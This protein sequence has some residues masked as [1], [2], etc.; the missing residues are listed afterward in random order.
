MNTD[1]YNFT[2]LAE[3]IYSVAAHSLA[4]LFTKPTEEAM[5]LSVEKAFP[6]NKSLEQAPLFRNWADL[7]LAGIEDLAGID[8]RRPPRW[9]QTIGEFLLTAEVE[10]IARQIIAVRLLADTSDDDFYSL[11]GI[12]AFLL[13][14]FGTASGLDVISG[15]A[16]QLVEVEPELFDALLKQC[17][18][19]LNW[20][21]ER[22]L[23]SAGQTSAHFRP[24]ELRSEFAAVLPKKELLSAEYDLDI[25]EILVFEQHYLRQTGRYFGRV[26]PTNLKKVRSYPP[27]ML[28]M[29]RLGLLRPRSQKSLMR[30][31][32]LP[33]CFVPYC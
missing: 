33:V 5:G 31:P 22:G 28:S 1:L 6:E 21:R 24:N 20:I 11:R 25:R 14:R 12:F 27:S 4:S 16:D 18:F 26:N 13:N 23:L 8:L 29:S 9:I 3:L 2:T 32:F 10:E 30:Q 19:H 15:E 17:D 7:D